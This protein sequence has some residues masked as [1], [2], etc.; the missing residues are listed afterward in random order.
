MD[1]LIQLAHNVEIGANTVIA[2]QTG[3]SGSSKI[4]KNSIIGGQVGIV[5]HISIA[6]HSHIQAKSGINRSIEEEGKKWAGA[7]ATQYNNHMRAQVV[8][9]RLPELEKEIREI[10]HQISLFSQRESK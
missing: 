8:F 6:K 1:N 5:G 4:G 9:Q 7:P 2:S 3:I 10:Q